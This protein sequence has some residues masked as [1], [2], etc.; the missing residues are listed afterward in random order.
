MMV[1]RNGNGLGA[2]PRPT[3]R[4]T[5]VR[6]PRSP[7]TAKQALALRLYDEGYT[8][9]V[10]GKALGWKNGNGIRAL[11]DVAMLKSGRGD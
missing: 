4:T 7:L 5:T 2:V 8:H 9:D 6:R 10:I 3:D 11:L 1:A